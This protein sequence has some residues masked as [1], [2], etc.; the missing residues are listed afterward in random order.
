MDT[1]IMITAYASFFYN[2]IKLHVLDY[3]GKHFLLVTFEFKQNATLC[4]LTACTHK[5]SGFTG[6]KMLQHD[7]F[8]QP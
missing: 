8:S 2:V 6:P 5:P 1:F 3:K 4:C 7:L